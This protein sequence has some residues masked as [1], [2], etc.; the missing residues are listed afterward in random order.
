[1]QRTCAS[2]WM[3]TRLPNCITSIFWSGNLNNKYDLEPCIHGDHCSFKVDVLHGSTDVVVVFLPIAPC[4]VGKCTA[5]LDCYN[6]TA[7]VSWSPVSGANSYMVTA[8]SADGS[9]VSC[10]STEHQ[11][12]LTELECGQVYNITLVTISDHCRT[13]KSTNISFSTRELSRVSI[14]ILNLFY[15]LK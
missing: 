5:N 8:V 7:T 3:C 15:S 1:M 2:Q 9:R 12:N 6:D 13:E 4:A 10:E 14:T 11:C